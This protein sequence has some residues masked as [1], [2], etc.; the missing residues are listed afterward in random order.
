MA[1]V[2]PFR[3]LRFTSLEQVSRRLAPDVASLSESERRSRAEQD[4]LHVLRLYDSPDPW[5][6]L[7]R[8]EEQG[9]LISEEPSMYVVE[10]AP[11]EPL[12]RKTAVRF[13]LGAMRAEEEGVSE[14]ERLPERIATPPL[15]PVTVLAADDHQVLRTLFAEVVADNFPVWESTV[16]GQRLR[17][18][19]V[20]N[21]G[22]A[23]RLRSTL[24]EVPTRPH[25]RV[26]ERGAFLAAIVP[27]SDPGLTLVPFH[28]GIR[29]LET[30]DPVR[31]LALMK[32]F[33][34]VYDLDAPLTNDAGLAAAREK[35]ANLSVGRHAVLFVKPDGH[36]CVLRFLQALELDH[37]P[38]APKNPTLRSLDLALLNALVL[39]T[40]L[41]IQEPESPRHPNIYPLSSLHELVDKV[42]GGTFQAGFALNPPPVW[43]LRAVME[44]AQSLPPRTM[45]VAPTPPAGLLFLDPKML[46]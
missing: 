35:L 33:A 2:L 46:G 1:R 40:V 32:D 42:V 22:I 39:R 6:A 12:L 24:E 9:H 11:A 31:F 19:R 29:G 26:P 4:P 16:E 45:R 41:G 3:A 38:A 25:G 30:F 27:L 18:W 17:M 13:L 15:E 44:A 34:R 10:S 14:M 43:E 23:R 7:R 36:G 20:S 37:I 21:A 5:A 8:W 28:R